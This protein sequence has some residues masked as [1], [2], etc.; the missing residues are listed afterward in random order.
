MCNTPTMGREIKKKKN[1]SPYRNKSSLSTVPKLE[2]R[3]T[4]PNSG[5][6]SLIL[7][8]D[9]SLRPWWSRSVIKR[10]P[11]RV[12]GAGLIVPAT[13]PFALVKSL[14]LSASPF[15]DKPLHMTTGG[16]HGSNQKVLRDL[17][18]RVFFYGPN[19][20]LPIS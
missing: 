7:E 3:G 13:F 17:G 2:S 18:P 10:I 9:N 11:F 20:L 19:P 15:S 1:C 6:G 12:P 8:P 5:Q 4:S 16:D 14:S